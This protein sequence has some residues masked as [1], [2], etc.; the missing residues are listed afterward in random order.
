MTK[1]PESSVPF[2]KLF[3]SYRGRSLPVCAGH[4]P[5]KLHVGSQEHESSW[6]TVVISILQEESIPFS[7]L[8]KYAVTFSY[9][10]ITLSSP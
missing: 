4:L 7:P 10:A 6:S 5:Q 3:L 2:W 9:S 8:R 1:G